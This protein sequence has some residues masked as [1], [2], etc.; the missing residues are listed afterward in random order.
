MNP[1]LSTTPFPQS[2]PTVALIVVTSFAF[3]CV[4]D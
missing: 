4:R 1:F 2:A 3:V